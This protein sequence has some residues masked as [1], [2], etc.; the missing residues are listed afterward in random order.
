MLVQDK[1]LE[2]IEMSLLLEGVFRHYGFDFRDYA[3]ASLRRRIL[4][5]VREEGLKSISALQA[6]L[7]HEPRCM[8]RFLLTMSVHVTALF[9]DPTFYLAF[10]RRVVPLLRTYPF[11]RIWHAGCSTGEEV[12]S[13]AILLKE[14]GLYDRCRLYAT[15][16]NEV[17]LAKAKEGVFP[18]EKMQD[19]TKNYQQAGGTRTF[20]HYYTAAYDRAMLH[21][22]LQE[23]VIFAQHNLATDG[24]FNEFHVV[25]C[26]NV[27]IYFN[28]ELQD[29]VHR[30][31][32]ESLGTFGILALGSRESLRFTP[33]E[34]A[35]ADIDTEAKLY[36]KLL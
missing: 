32:Y 22:S 31:L 18:L 12:Y 15:D 30:L 35:Y 5:F 34:P 10:R 3:P 28:K 20:S 8:E 19:Y 2:E 4:H 6:R 23:N 21:D 14:E 7:L 11:I 26:R 1:S 24:S 29:R 27:L 9:R 36:R 16:M 17:V 13:M 25:F 33:Y